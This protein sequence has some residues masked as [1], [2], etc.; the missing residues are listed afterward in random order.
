MAKLYKHTLQTAAVRHNQRQHKAH[1]LGHAQFE[2]QS[3]FDINELIETPQTRTSIALWNTFVK[4]ARN[5]P[6]ER[7]NFAN[8]FG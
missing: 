5:V 4:L 7:G 6:I 1:Y 8:G 2:V 3:R